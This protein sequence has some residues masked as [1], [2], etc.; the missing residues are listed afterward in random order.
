MHGHWSKSITNLV[1]INTLVHCDLLSASWNLSH[2]SE[3]Y[4]FVSWDHDIPNLDGPCSIAMSNCQT[5][6]VPWT[7]SMGQSGIISTGFHFRGSREYVAYG[8]WWYHMD[9]Q[10]GDPTWLGFTGTSRQVTT[11]NWLRKARAMFIGETDDNPLGF[12]ETS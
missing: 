1:T 2:P 5:G 4:E 7:R 10:L 11:M 9:T 3:K 8:Y 6:E 12:W